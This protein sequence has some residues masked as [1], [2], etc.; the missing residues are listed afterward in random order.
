[1]LPIAEKAIDSEFALAMISSTGPDLLAV[2][3]AN[4]GKDL[5]NAQVWQAVLGSPMPPDVTDADN[6]FGARLF[7]DFKTRY[8]AAARETAP[9]VSEYL[10]EQNLNVTCFSQ[11]L[12]PRRMLELTLPG[13]GIT[14]TDL[15]VSTGMGTLRNYDQTTAYGLV[16]DFRRR[17]KGTVMTF[18]DRQGQD[19]VVQ[20]FD[21]PDTENTPDHPI[22]QEI[23]GKVGAMTQ[24]EAQTARVL[25]AFSQA[26]VISAR[27][28]STAFP[29]TY[30]SEHGNFSVTAKEQDNGTVVIDIVSDPSL[31]L[32]FA[33]QFTVNTDGS[34]TCTG[35]TMSRRQE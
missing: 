19:Y 29:G 3:Q 5:S 28:L 21:I 22:F 6:I 26:G 18:E 9:E 24:S 13:G 35:F 33:Q 8:L 30:M 4:G 14:L 31:P 27:M 10:L 23:I 17:D 32:T 25:Q 1:L 11:M 34:H 15:G 7:E 20:P 16:T 2:L 12:S